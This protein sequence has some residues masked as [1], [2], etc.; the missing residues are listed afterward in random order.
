MQLALFR[1][2]T[3][4][5]FVQDIE[6]LDEV[7]GISLAE[8]EDIPLLFQ[9]VA[10]N[11]VLLCIEMAMSVDDLGAVRISLRSLPVVGS[12]IERLFYFEHN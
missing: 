12:T 3:A 9:D 2:E 10:I 4:W 11:R 6:D 1:A 5:V 7:G 8:L